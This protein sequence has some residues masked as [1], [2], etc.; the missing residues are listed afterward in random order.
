MSSPRGDGRVRRAAVVAALVLLLALGVCAPHGRE[1]AASAAVPAGS[2]APASGATTSVLVLWERS[3]P[4]AVRRG[5]LA[6]LGPVYPTSRDID[7]VEVA[8]AEAPELARR[9]SARPEVV[10]AEV[11]RPVYLAETVPNDPLFDQQWGLR[12]PG[13]LVGLDGQRAQEG[14]DVGALDAWALTRGSPEVTVALV[15]SGID[16]THP[17]LAGSLWV[18][19]EEVADGW[20]SDGNGVVDDVHGFDVI[21][22]LGIAEPEALPP[23]DHGT[24]VASVLAARADDGVGMAGM[25]P[26]IQIL[27]VRAFVEDPFEPGAGQGTLQS[28][29]AGLSYAIEAGA[30]VINVSWETPASCT[31]LERVVAEAGVP[32]VAAAGNRGLDL[33]L[34]EIGEVYPAGYRLPNL[35]AVTA[36]DPFGEVPAFATT[37]AGT[38]DLG[39]P[40]VSIVG[41]LPGGGYADLSNGPR[42]GTSFAVPFV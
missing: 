13:R 17:D 40:G 8:V 32:V 19:P 18:N 3:T 26:E 16:L 35:V 11:D 41:A 30:D 25:A 34:D 23:E 39:A 5:L 6:D 37:G 2:P 38:I 10:V 22:Q 14:L 31:L 33:D 29:V 21:A 36:L 42:P 15:D 1:H 4:P 27:P 12:N 7:S 9:L 28:V 20:D 24:L